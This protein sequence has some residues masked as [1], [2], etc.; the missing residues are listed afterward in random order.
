M[1]LGGW[2][3]RGRALGHKK[4]PQ[5]RFFDNFRFRFLSDGGG[6]ASA[7][8][9]TFSKISFSVIFVTFLLSF[10][11][12]CVYCVFR[13]RSCV[14]IYANC[15]VFVVFSSWVSLRPTLLPVCVRDRV[16]CIFSLFIFLSLWLSHSHPGRSVVFLSSTGSSP[17]LSPSPPP[18]LSAICPSHI[19]V[20]CSRS[21]SNTLLVK[22]PKWRITAH[23]HFFIPL[24]F[25]PL[26]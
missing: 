22:L 10:C 15:G 26:E 5:F 21:A 11:Y 3:K 4:Q 20:G 9:P 13:V 2:V 14:K 24:F 25:L 8:L 1:W 18:T 7:S 23:L 16:D 12:L 19:S 6:S 17:R